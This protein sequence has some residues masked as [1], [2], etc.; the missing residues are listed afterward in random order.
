MNT[1]CW[2]VLLLFLCAIKSE[3]QECGTDCHYELKGKSL[4]IWGT[5]EITDLDLTSSEV[6]RKSIEK[7]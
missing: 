3:S 1:F 2:A 7:N 6:D 4:R 5:G